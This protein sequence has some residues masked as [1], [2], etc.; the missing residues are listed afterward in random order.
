M[1]MPHF[2]DHLSSLTVPA[3]QDCAARIKG[4]ESAADDVAWW[5]AT[6]AVDRALTRAGTGRAAGLAASAAAGTVRDAAARG[7]ARLPDRDVT[8]AARSA[9]A[10]ARALIAG[11]GG[12]HLTLLLRPWRLESEGSDR[13]PD[14]RARWRR[15]AVGSH[16]AVA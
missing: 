8:C 2:I 9:A 12:P 14:G 10:V 15:Y 7:G 5:R 6:L 1:D 13:E 11:V 16:S 4:A 3:I